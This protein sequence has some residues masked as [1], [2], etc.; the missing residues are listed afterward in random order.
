VTL[1]GLTPFMI[2]FQNP[3]ANANAITIAEGASN[4]YSGL[5][6][7]FKIVL[8]PGEECRILK[9]AASAV[10]SGSKTFDLTGTGAQALGVQIAAG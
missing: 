4:G 7:S 9:Q 3:S 5:G 8:Q 6:A 10:G 1:S 2:L